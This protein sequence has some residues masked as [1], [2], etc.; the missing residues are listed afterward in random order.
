[1]PRISQFP[2]LPTPHGLTLDIDDVVHSDLIWTLEWYNCLFSYS[3]M[4]SFSG[5]DDFT[6][7]SCSESNCGFSFVHVNGMHLSASCCM[8]QQGALVTPCV[9]QNLTEIL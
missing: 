5:M 1:M 2:S 9:I 7:R 8:H 4:F 6:D 3:A